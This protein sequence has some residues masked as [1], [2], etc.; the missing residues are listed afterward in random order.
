MRMIADV[1]VEHAGFPAR[2][3]PLRC[4][5]CF[6]PASRGRPRSENGVSEALFQLAFTRWI[7]RF[8]P[9]DGG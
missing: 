4:R 8:P 7:E 1:T 2:H 5:S 3:P 9:A 6:A